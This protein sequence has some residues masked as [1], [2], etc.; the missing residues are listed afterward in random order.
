MLLRDWLV[1]LS[2]RYEAAKKEEE[3][4]GLILN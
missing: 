2:N 1:S 4:G 3:L